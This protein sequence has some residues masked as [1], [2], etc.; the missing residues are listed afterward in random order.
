MFPRLGHEPGSSVW[1]SL[2]FGKKVVR[3]HRII[4]ITKQYA[5][6]ASYLLKHFSESIP[7]D[8][9]SV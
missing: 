8:M 1:Y 4:L 9:C 3:K 2:E 5:M 6:V 7:N